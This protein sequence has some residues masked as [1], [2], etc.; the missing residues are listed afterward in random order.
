MFFLPSGLDDVIQQYVAHF[1]DRDINGKKLMMLT[2]SDLENVGVHKLG[3]QELI[4]E[5]VDLLKS[6]VCL[7][8]YAS[9]GPFL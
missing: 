3:H 1:K 5:A 6:L 9:K 4:L 8:F 7:Q 2:H